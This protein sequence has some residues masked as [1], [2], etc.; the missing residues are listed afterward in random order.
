MSA[1]RLFHDALAVAPSDPTT[2][3]NIVTFLI[4]HGRFEE[5][6]A[7]LETLRGMNRLGSLD[8]R[9]AALDA[10]LREAASPAGGTSVR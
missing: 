6:R 3:A 2:H 9:I 8:E 10:T 4:H 1:E 7:E 5:A